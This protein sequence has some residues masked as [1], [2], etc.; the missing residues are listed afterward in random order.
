MR[1]ILQVFK[2]QLQYLTEK[3]KVTAENLSRVHLAGEKAYELK[4]PDFKSILGQIDQSS[5]KTT[6][7]AQKSTCTSD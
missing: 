3:Q 1:N 7:E 6:H 2:A 4:E 5:A